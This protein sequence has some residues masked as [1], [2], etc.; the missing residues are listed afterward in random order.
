MTKSLDVPNYV[1]KTPATISISGAT[2]SGKTTLLRR[3]LDELTLFSSPPDRIIYCYG[4]W[5]KAFED[6]YNIE[7]LKGVQIP[8]L[9]VNQ[10]TLIIFDDLM[11][12]VVQNKE[13]QLLFTEGSHHYNCSVVLIL[14]NLFQQG[15]CSKSIMLNVH[16]MFLMNNAR[17]VGQIKNLGRQMGMEKWVIEAYNDCMAKRYSYLLID[18]SP[19]KV[20]QEFTLSTNIFSDQFRVCYIPPKDVQRRL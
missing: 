9:D 10:H 11:S 12:T 13:A 17:D 16:Y 15:K 4:V 8:D 14:Q 18:L 3:I 19:H 1:F 5:Q 2:G 7:F 20:C 6:M